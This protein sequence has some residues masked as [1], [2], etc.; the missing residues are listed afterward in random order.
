MIIIFIPLVLVRYTKKNPAGV[1]S[2]RGWEESMPKNQVLFQ[3]GNNYSAPLS[4]VKSKAAEKEI[5]V[6]VVN[7]IHFS[8]NF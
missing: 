6:A 1:Y 8:L 3:A 7:K 5:K 4:K 2:Q